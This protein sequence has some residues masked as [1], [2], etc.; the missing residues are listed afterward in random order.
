MDPDQ[1]KTVADN[2]W[3]NDQYNLRN[4]HQKILLNRNSNESSKWFKK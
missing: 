2:E 3:M 4:A 1:D